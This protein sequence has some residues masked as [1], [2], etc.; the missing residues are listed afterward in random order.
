M[1]RERSLSVVPGILAQLG[2]A[3]VQ[4]VLGLWFGG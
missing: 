3:A 1:I 4:A 2:A